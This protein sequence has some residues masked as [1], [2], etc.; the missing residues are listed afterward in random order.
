MACKHAGPLQ[1]IHSGCPATPLY[2][3]SLLRQMQNC[4]PIQAVLQLAPK[5]S[6]IAV[7]KHRLFVIGLPLQRVQLVLVS[8]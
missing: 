4:F 8:C 6:R 2:P 1:K 3:Q 7:V 5:P